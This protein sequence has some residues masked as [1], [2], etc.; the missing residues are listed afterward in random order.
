MNSQSSL[1]RSKFLC[2][3]I[4]FF[5]ILITHGISPVITST[6]ST[7]SIYSA[8]S[9]I[10]EGNLDLNEYR[11][12]IKAKKKFG[13]RIKNGRY[14]NFFPPGS[15]LLATPFVWAFEKWPRLWVSFM[16][17]FSRFAS[18]VEVSA[19]DAHL[20]L[21]RFTGSFCVALSAVFILLSVALNFPLWW[22]AVLALIYAF[23]TPAWS[24]FSR[25]LWQHG[26]GALFIT[27]ALYLAVYSRKNERLLAWSAVPLAAAYICRPTNIIAVFAFFVLV[28]LKQSRRLWLYLALL[29]LTLSPFVLW[30]LECFNRV[31]PLYYRS[32]RLSLTSS[33]P[34]ALAANLISPARG[35]FIFSPFLVFSVLSI[36][37]RTKIRSL[38][39]LE[40]TVIAI[41]IFHW[42]TVSSFPVWWGG[43]SY[44][45]RLMSDMVPYLLLVSA[46]LYYWDFKWKRLTLSLFALTLLISVVIHARGANS[47]AVHLWN[48][49]PRNIDQDSSRVWNFRDLQFL[50]KKGS[51]A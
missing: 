21:E 49:S 24:I 42:L 25:G 35:L 29:I 2:G 32:T 15:A 8:K 19:E 33:Y 39:A 37:K 46:S 44:G 34:E 36:L 23:A 16:P 17:G 30:S 13:V 27:I 48:A 7:W 31:V 26:P 41:C 40:Y 51:G 14:Y 6:D 20:E 3:L 12:R 38:N 5:L 18:K 50:R 10:S 11:D 9:L 4:L 45:P 1:N 47:L 22:S 43:H 28:A